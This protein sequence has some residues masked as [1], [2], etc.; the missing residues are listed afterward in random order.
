M[1]N[2]PMV[3]K[4][5]LLTGVIILVVVMVLYHIFLGKRK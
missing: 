5:T 2:M 3:H 1:P 4:P